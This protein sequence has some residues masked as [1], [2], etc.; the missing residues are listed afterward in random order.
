MGTNKL[1]EGGIFYKTSIR[2]AHENYNTTFRNYDIGLLKTS[3]T[4]KFN[5]KVQPIRLPHKN[6]MLYTT[7]P[8]T[9]AGWGKTKVSNS[10]RTRKQMKF[11]FIDTLIIPDGGQEKVPRRALLP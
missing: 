6:P 7:M 2:I 4:I 11:S 3:K 8:V 5:R 9:V 1:H 10:N